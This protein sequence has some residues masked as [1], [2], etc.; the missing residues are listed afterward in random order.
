MTNV[1]ENLEAKFDEAMRDTYRVASEHGY[2]PGYFLQM[3]EAHGGVGTAKRLLA[4]PEYQS[5]LTD[6]WERSLL[7]IS[8]E[9]LVLQ[10]RWQSLFSDDE[11]RSAHERLK[12]HG[13]EVE[14]DEN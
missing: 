13:Y 12:A 14:V 6:L 8:A 3:I 1:A 7:G 11:R 9:A 10:E 2:R 4:K 5:G